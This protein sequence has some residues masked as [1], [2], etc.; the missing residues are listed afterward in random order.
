MR[1]SLT[2]S[3]HCLPL[4]PVKRKRTSFPSTATCRVFERRQAIAVVLLGIVVVPDANERGFQ[5]MDDGGEDLL[6]RK[7][8]AAPCARVT[9]AR[10]PGSA[11]GK[12][13][14]VFV[15][16]TLAHL[17]EPWLVA[18]LLAALGIPTGGLDVPFRKRADPDISPGRRDGKRPDPPENV[19]LR[20]P[21]A[22]SAGVGETFAGFSAADA[23]A[24]II[25][26]PQGRLIPPRPWD[27][28]LSARLPL[29][30][31]QGVTFPPPKST[32]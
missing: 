28:R 8:A 14:H 11:L 20:E 6:A 32:T 29:K 4:L 23:G 7:T 13:D 27:R 18:V 22:V 3:D 2:R 15:L 17:T 19:R 5:K 21:G 12:C 24:R 16:G 1:R 31:Q 30:L 10:T 25:D 9:F 26:V